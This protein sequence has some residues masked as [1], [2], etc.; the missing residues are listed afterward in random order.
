MGNHESLCLSRSGVFWQR[1][2]WMRVPV[3]LEWAV[4]QIPGKRRV[5]GC[6][7]CQGQHE[8]ARRQTDEE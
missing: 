7:C 8:E 4:V 1:V 2:E 6:S 3:H 5:L